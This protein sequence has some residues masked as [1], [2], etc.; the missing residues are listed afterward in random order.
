MPGFAIYPTMNDPVIFE[1]H[2]GEDWTEMTTVSFV[3]VPAIQRNFL[4]FKQEHEIQLALKTDD[5]KRIVTGPLLIPDMVVNRKVED[6]MFQI[7]FRQAEVVKVYE[8]FMAAGAYTNTNI[9]HKKDLPGDDEC[10]LYE[11]FMTDPDRGIKAPDG[12]ED[13][14][15]YTIFMSHKIIGDGLWKLIKDGDIKGYSLEGRFKMVP[16]SKDQESLKILQELDKLNSLV[17]NS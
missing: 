2:M 9:M 16:E 10:H 3:D 7:V 4:A 13:L 8:K 17:K 12:F 6:T 11:I 5:D 14:P 1:M 15:P